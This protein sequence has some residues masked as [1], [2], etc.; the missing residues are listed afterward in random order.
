[1]YASRHII[2]RQQMFL[3]FYTVN[4]HAECSYCIPN[5]LMGIDTLTEV[6]KMLSPPLSQSVYC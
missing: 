1:M 3:E 6:V 4:N 5:Q 2:A